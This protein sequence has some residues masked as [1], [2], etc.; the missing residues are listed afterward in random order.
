M[1]HYNVPLG[2][3]PLEEARR[4]G[5]FYRMTL[6]LLYDKNN[7]IYL[8]KI[9]RDD[10]PSCQWDLG[11]ETCLH[12]GEST[13][14]GAYRIIKECIGRETGKLRFAGTI[15]PSVATGRFFVALYKMKHCYQISPPPPIGTYLV[16][17]RDEL[18]GIVKS[19]PDLV[20]PRLAYLW[21]HGKLFDAW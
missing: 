4:Q 20:T 9:K 21:G 10:A 2:A 11:L 15:L 3:M 5:L 13:L 6:V 7:K 1:D 17:D 14:D 8:K 18:S 12:P 16:V 19:C